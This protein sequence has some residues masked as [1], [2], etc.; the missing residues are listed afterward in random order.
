M[1]TKTAIPVIL[2][3]AG[4][5]GL[6]A[7]TARLFCKNGYR[8]VVNYSSNAERAN[9]LVT[10]FAG[11]SPLPPAEHQGAFAAVRADLSQR[12]DIVALVDESVRRMGRL[13]V[14]FSN[15]GW[16]RIRDMTSI[17]DNT[18]EEDWDKCFNMNVKSHLW[19]M[20]AAKKH[21]DETEG[22]FITTASLAGVS[23]SGSSLAY[24]VTKA[25][26]IHLVKALANMA[27]PKIRV[28]S[29]SPGLLLT[30]WGDRFSDEAKEANLQKTKLKRLATVEDVAEQVFVFAKSRS[31]T[32]TN[33]II[34]SGFLLA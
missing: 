16:T 28:N 10:E 29:V 4:S 21:L 13:D 6:G 11:L 5:A 19:L 17:D 3:S 23:H 7:A 20:H 8:V 33:A 2:V 9:Q 32:G 27:A 15:G 25:A 26:Q 31:Q 24:S 1:A 34:D 14:V 22:A 18:F 30:E 12:D